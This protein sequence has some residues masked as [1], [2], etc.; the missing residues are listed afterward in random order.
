M[1]SL[2]N[3]VVAVASIAFCTATPA[4]AYL[5]GVKNSLDIGVIE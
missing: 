4:Q 2:L 3:N 1:R 5:A